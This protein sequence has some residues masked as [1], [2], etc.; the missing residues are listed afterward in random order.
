M[1]SDG[2][3]FDELRP[4]RLVPDYTENPLGSVLCQVGRT[5]VL[6]TV[7]EEMSV[8]RFLKATGRGW[9]FTGGGCYQ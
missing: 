6:C 7:S 4:V 9:I 2:R 1:R 3:A 5:M 8:P